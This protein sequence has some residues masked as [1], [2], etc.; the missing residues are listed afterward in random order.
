MLSV[1]THHVSDEVAVVLF[2]AIVL[3]VR[4]GAL[5]LARRWDGDSSDLA[6]LG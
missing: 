3:I 5:A 4:D 2:A 1:L 6:V